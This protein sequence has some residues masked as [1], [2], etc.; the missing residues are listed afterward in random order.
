MKASGCTR[1]GRFTI[2]RKTKAKRQ[3]AKL[4]EIKRDL[5]KRMHESVPDTGKWLRSVLQGHYQYFAV[6]YNLDT[7]IS[8]RYQVARAWIRMLRRRSHKARKRLTWEKFKRFS[9]SWLP[10]PRI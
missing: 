7:L 1:K 3:R 9:D 2:R 8:L 4:Q 10:K 5:S 6:P